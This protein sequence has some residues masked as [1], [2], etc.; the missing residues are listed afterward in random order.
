[1]L[2]KGLRLLVTLAEN[3]PVLVGLAIR[4]LLVFALDDGLALY[5]VRYTDV[6][7]DV[8]TDAARHLAD[9]RSPY[10]RHTYRYTPFLAQ[11]LAQPLIRPGIGTVLA[12]RFF[13]KVL[14]CAADVIC[15][16]LI[17]AL[18]R[19]QRAHEREA[20]RSGVANY[21]SPAFEDALWWLYNPLP[22]NICTRG[23]AESLVV[24]LP[25]LATVAVAEAA[26]RRPPMPSAM[27]SGRAAP[28]AARACVAGILHGVGIHAKLFPVIYTVSFMAHFSRQQH[29]WETTLKSRGGTRFPWRH[30]GQVFD[31]AIAWTRRLFLTGSS[32]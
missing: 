22:I 4:L 24:L 12:P 7:Y 27:R 31:L 32:M 19:R 13:G 9:G 1:M 26:P 8:F 28:V 16:A 23:S 30:P 25:V 15:G 29:R 18:R 11:L 2:R 3:Q 17:V 10:A 14:F 20:G 5:G 21:F 6:D